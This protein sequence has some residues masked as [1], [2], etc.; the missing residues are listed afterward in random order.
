MTQ[1][2]NINRKSSATEL[3]QP[4]QFKLEFIITQASE[5]TKNAAPACSS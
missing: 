4:A 1:F 3:E 5:F 2:G